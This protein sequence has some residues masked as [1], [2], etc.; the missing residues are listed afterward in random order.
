VSCALVLLLAALAPASGR[1][2]EARVH[3]LPSD[4]VKAAFAAGEPLLEQ[5]DLEVHASRRSGPGQVEIHERETDVIY[6]LEGTAVFVTGGRLLGGAPVAP[7]EIRGASVEGGESRTLVPGDVIVVPRGVPHWFR[8][9]PGAF[10][11]YVV[12]VIA[13]EDAR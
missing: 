6:V 7:G 2:E 3:Y 8:E 12:K 10:T 4:R 1:G 13:P 9:V 5:G 11:Y